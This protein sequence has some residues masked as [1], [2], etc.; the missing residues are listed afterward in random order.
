M[1]KSI[2][3]IEKRK[4]EI[5]ATSFS[6]EYTSESIK[7]WVISYYVTTHIVTM[8]WWYDC[9]KNTY[10]SKGYTSFFNME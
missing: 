4:C 3:E 8:A 2:E 6:Q 10:P 7:K 9:W 5:K 1:P